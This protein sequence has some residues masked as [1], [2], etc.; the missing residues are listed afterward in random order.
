MMTTP[1]RHGSLRAIWTALF[2]TVLWS[3]SWVLIR[4]VLDDD[5]LAPV[6]F[7][8]LRYGLAAIV[9]CLWCLSRP[10]DRRALTD[11]DRATVGR[12]VLLGVVFFSVTQAAQF[13]AIGSQPAASTSLVLSLTTFL[14]AVLS[15]RTL[16]ERPSRRQFLGAALVAVGAAMYFSGDLGATTVG[17]TAAIVALVA[18]SVGSMLGRRVNRDRALAPVVVTTVSMSVGAMVLLVVGV[19]VEGWPRLTAVSVAIIGWLAVVNTAV[20]FTLW[21][22]S[23]RRLTAVESSAINN[24]MLIQIAMLAWIFLGEAP[25][26]AGLVGIFTVAAGVFFAQTFLAEP[27]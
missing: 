23:L 20:A 3:S 24:T 1:D 10:R 16:G 17:L 7:A 25:G 2:V 5:S 11:L 6:T 4:M 12:L 27:E 18:N 9:L 15:L 22:A 14:V 21:N 26:V 19:A 8:G 13:V